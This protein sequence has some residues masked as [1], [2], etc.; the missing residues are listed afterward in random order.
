MFPIL[1]KALKKSLGDYGIEITTT[2]HTLSVTWLATAFTL[3][4][5]LFWLFSTC[6]CS[7]QSNP[8]HRSNKEAPAAELGFGG[9]QANQAMSGGLV[10]GRSL[11]VEKTG[12]YERVQSPYASNGEGDNVPMTTVAAPPYSHGEANSYYQ[13]PQHAPSAYEPYRHN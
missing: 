11:K 3:L 6:C 2:K 9:N 1:V 7:G 5:T 8:H 4:A 13:Q 10:R 12:G